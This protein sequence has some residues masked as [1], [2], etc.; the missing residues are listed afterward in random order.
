MQPAEMRGA[1]PTQV[2][3]AA[4]KGAEDGS[5][6]LHRRGGEAELH[7]TPELVHPVVL[8]AR[9]EHGGHLPFEPPGQHLVSLVHDDVFDPTG[10]HPPVPHH[11]E[12]PGGR[13][14]ENLGSAKLRDRLR[15]PRELGPLLSSLDRVAVSRSPG[16]VGGGSTPR[17]IR[18]GVA[19][20]GGFL[21]RGALAPR[22]GL[23]G[24]PGRHARGANGGLL[25]NLTLDRRRPRRAP[26]SRRRGF[27]ELLVLSQQR[28]NRGLRVFPRVHPLRR[29]LRHVR[30]LS[31]ELHVRH[32][33]D[34]RRAAPAL[35]LRS[36]PAGRADGG[37]HRQRVRKRLSAPGLREDHHVL[38]GDEGRDGEALD[39][40]RA[41]QARGAHGVH[42]V[43][44][45]TRAGKGGTRV[46]VGGVGVG[47]GSRVIARVRRRLGFPGGARHLPGP[48]PASL[49]RGLDRQAGAPRWATGAGRGALG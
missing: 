24:F 6:L 7:L 22:G 18:G 27:E 8:V 45:Q 19:R 43:R 13:G 17:E 39:L 25:L 3:G 46:L 23:G 37:D 28:E 47:V 14:D 15:V 49:V 20:G 48:G 35:N 38:A 10:Q 31:P 2:L 5:L 36:P 41:L 34:H 21:V 12:E 42:H 32:E 26:R 1:D 29:E 16:D 44:G 30:H 33:H 4:A 9:L 40:R 11:G